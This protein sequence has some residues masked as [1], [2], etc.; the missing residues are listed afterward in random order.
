MIPITKDLLERLIE[1]SRDLQIEWEWRAG[2]PT[3]GGRA[4]Q[5]LMDDIAEGTALLSQHN[6]ET[7]K[8]EGE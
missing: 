4:Y 3:S 6:H 1:N 8:N 5:M 7:D 2:A